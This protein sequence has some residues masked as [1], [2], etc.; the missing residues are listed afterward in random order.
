VLAALKIC[1]DGQLFK[2]AMKTSVL[3]SNADSFHS[4]VS[5][6]N[7]LEQYCRIVSPLRWDEVFV[8]ML[9]ACFDAGG[10]E[11]DHYNVLSVAGFASF[12][13]MWSEFTERWNAR[14]AKDSLPYFHAG[15]FA[16]SV[17]V[18]SHG[19]KHDEQRRRA[20]VT[21]L[22]DIIHEC[23]LRKFGSVIRIDDYKDVTKKW[24]P[25]GNLDAWPL[26]DA[27]AICSMTCIED[28]Y[29]Y[30]SGE[31]VTNNLRYVFEKGD[32]EE[33]LRLICRGKKIPDPD[34]AWSREYVDSKGSKHDPFVGLQ[35]AGWIAYEYYL[36]ADR[37]L[38][39]KPS[40]RWAFRQ[41]ETI[42][43]HVKVLHHKELAPNIPSMR[44]IMAARCD[45][46][47]DSTFWL[48]LIALS[49][50]KDFSQKLP[51]DL[52]DGAEA[53]SRFRKQFESHLKSTE[54]DATRSHTS[55][56]KKKR[57]KGK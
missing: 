9:T 53:F 39:G 16:H 55:S 50:D 42:P 21:D 12:A 29:S 51:Q 28:F 54:S 15:D 27:F 26:L 47:R 44:K 36:G 20:L 43:G 35:A 5:A 13:G 3:S 7:G 34:F 18:F 30:A 24:N 25:S 38:S 56:K 1:G 2:C 32:P 45:A 46:V 40:D 19:W 17:K 6:G 33:T 4:L 10:K 41:F 22:M 11:S 8:Q 48:E 49:K 57:R 37:L 14:L 31:G 23:G 52:F